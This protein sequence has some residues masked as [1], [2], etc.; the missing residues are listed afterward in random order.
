M[1]I[2][3]GALTAYHDAMPQLSVWLLYSAAV[4]WTLAYDTI[5]ACQD[6]VDDQRTGVTSSALFF[7]EH[8]KTAVL[9][10]YAAMFALLTLAVQIA[11]YSLLTMISVLPVAGITLW[12]TWQRF[13]PQNPV[14]CLRGFK[15]NGWLGLVILMLLVI[16]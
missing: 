15:A 9:G 11:G 5:Y 10:S 1:G 4:C 6:M 3:L 12:L 16:T 13:D 8:I 14:A 2:L 7:G